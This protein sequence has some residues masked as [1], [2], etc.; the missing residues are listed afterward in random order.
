MLRDLG[1][2]AVGLALLGACDVR[3]GAAPKGAMSRIG[4]LTPLVAGSSD[5]RRAIADLRD[6]LAEF[7]YREGQTINVDYRH[8]GTGDAA[9][10]GPLAAEL[11]AI[12]SLQLFVCSGNAAI[13]EMKKRTTKPIVMGTS[14]DPVENGI[15]AS[16][17]RPGATSQAS[18]FR[19]SR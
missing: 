10:I 14:P 4:V 13:V 12:A 6:G 19:A 18:P 5:E 11:A 1:R 3:T 16:L 9:V 15:I 2:S 7:G 8:A 17:A